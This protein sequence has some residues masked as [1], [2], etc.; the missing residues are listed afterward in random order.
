VHQNCEGDGVTRAEAVERLRVWAQR[1]QHEAAQADT[2]ASMLQWQAQ[3]QV[4]AAVANFVANQDPQTPDDVVYR[5]VVA[6]RT[7]SLTE[8]AAREGGEAAA[9]YAGGVAGYDLALTTIRDMSG[10]VWPR[11]DAHSG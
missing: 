9:F 6:D 4:L 7:R 10:R 3:A 5:L 2:R 8:W 1:A 11:V